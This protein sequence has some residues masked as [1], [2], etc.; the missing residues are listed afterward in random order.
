VCAQ[1]P[2]NNFLCVFQMVGG[3]TTS[4]LAFILPCMFFLA[5]KRQ[6]HSYGGV[7]VAVY[8]WLLHGLIIALG[9]FGGVASTKSAVQSC[10]DSS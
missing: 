1:V 3:V 5:L 4:P 8:E 2:A 10:K 6:R 9:V 7:S